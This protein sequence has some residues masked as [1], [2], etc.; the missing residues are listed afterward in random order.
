MAPSSD[1]VTQLFRYLDA[2]RRALQRLPRP[3]PEIVT[4]TLAVVASIKKSFASVQRGDASAALERVNDTVHSL[5]SYS[6]TRS[7]KAFQKDIEAIIEHLGDVAA[8]LRSFL[9]PARG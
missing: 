4:S 5:A 1:N 6:I 9:D 8:L 7:A 3:E 2:A